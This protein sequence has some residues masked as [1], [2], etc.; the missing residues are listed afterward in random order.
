MIDTTE[1]SNVICQ[2]LVK[3]FAHHSPL[4]RDNLIDLVFPVHHLALM[5]YL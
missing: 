3:E 2:S 5:F 4:R 1:L